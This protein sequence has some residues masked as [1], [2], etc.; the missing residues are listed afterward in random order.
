MTDP[1]SPV[2]PEV[3]R[4]AIDDATMRRSAWTLIL[5]NK[6][7]GTVTAQR[8]PQGRRTVFDV[9]GDAARGLVAIGRL[10]RASTG[11]LLFTN[12]TQLANWL[13]DPVNHVP[14]RYVVTVKGRVDPATATDLE[15]GMTI[16]GP[17]KDERLRASRV[18]I[19]KASGRETHL[20]VD[21]EEGRNREIRRLFEAAGHEVTRLHRIA[22]GGLA[23]G[24]L[25][26]G[27]WRHVTRQELEHAM[28]SSPGE[29][30]IGPRR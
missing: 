29:S 2:T 9:L 26:P 5:L 18:M 8:D 14:R 22:F 10:D 7:R 3:V 21:L 24:S 19:R 6:P 23:L 17:G 15:R 1:R 27:A 25:E 12:D 13:T 30:G 4:I 20:I 28:R 11:L 16:R